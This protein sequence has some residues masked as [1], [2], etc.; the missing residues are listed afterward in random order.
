M[1]YIEMLLPAGLRLLLEM[2]G[3]ADLTALPGDRQAAL[4][5][6]SQVKEGNEDGLFI[7]KPQDFYFLLLSM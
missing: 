7:Q 6:M 5:Y 1:L 4:V 2:Q 3:A